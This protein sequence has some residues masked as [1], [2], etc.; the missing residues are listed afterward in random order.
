[1]SDS[2]E[3]TTG[4]EPTGELSPDVQAII[5][6]EISKAK[7]NYENQMRGLNRSVSN[8]QKELAEKNAAGKS[9]EERTADIERELQ[10]AKARAATMEAFGRKGLSE[11]WRS[12]FDIKDPEARADALSG[13]LEDHTKALQKSIAT[14]FVRDPEEPQGDSG[15][16][17]SFT[18]P[19]LKGKT[20][21]EINKLW[22]EGRVVA[23]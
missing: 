10:S 21:A 3:P 14:Q 4:N 22:N 9:I 8:L 2:I 1:M 17:R 23:S 6:A 11:E 15:G 18:M 7:E 12:L 20:P 16:K 13:L 19:E 5:D